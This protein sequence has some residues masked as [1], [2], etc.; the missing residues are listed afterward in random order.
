[1]TATALQDLAAFYLDLLGLEVSSVQVDGKTTWYSRNGQELK[2]DAPATL[3]QGAGFTVTVTYSG[4]PTHLKSEL[5][6]G[7]QKVGHTIFT[8]DEPEGAT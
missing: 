8:L 5:V 2:V 1:M 4:E 3:P 7:W 6:M